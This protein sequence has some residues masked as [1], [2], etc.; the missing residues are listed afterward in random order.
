[1][2]K[3]AV[4]VIILAVLAV[5][6]DRIGAAVGQHE[7]AAQL[8]SKMDLSEEPAVTVHHIPFLTQVIRGKYSDI[9]VDAKGVE[10][11]RFHDL[12][13][14]VNLHGAK[15][16]LGDLLSGSIDNLPVDTV[17][18]EVMVTYDDLARASGVPGMTIKR[19]GDGVEASVP[20]TIGGRQVT[21]SAVVTPTLV[22]GDAIR[23][24][25]SQ[26]SIPGAAGSDVNLVNGKRTLTFT[27]PL[28]LRF[29]LKATTLDVRDD[30]L[31]LAG[32]AHDVT[33][34]SDMR[35]GS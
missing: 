31:R 28:D 23:V 16:P 1:M 32:A 27:V 8:K 12:N 14:S 7:L 2:R 13:L 18:G 17:G 29:G 24:R 30:G 3:L 10:S 11:G 6:A 5:A 25:A 22:S 26:V 35:T 20:E 21:L 15:A 34:T 19:S 4:A 33:L 9:E